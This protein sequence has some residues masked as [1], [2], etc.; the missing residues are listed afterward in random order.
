MLE[1]QPG[2]SPSNHYM[3]SGMSSTLPELIGNERG[4]WSSLGP[5]PLLLPYVFFCAGSLFY[6]QREEV[7]LWGW[8]NLPGLLHSLLLCLH[9]FC[10]W[11][12][13]LPH[14]R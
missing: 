11:S 13:Q 2:S 9:S 8:W 5:F 10:T 1:G 12:S 3:T 7:G 6:P 4:S 14:H